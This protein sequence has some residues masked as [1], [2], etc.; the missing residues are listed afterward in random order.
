M[1]ILILGIGNVL[2]AD[3]GAGVHFVRAFEKAYKMHSSAHSV[4]FID[5]G[6]LANH[7]SPIIAEFDKA[8][9]VDCIESDDGALGDVYFFD[10]EAMPHFV[11]FSGSAH[12]VEMLQTL[13]MMDLLGDRPPT[14]ILAV[15]PQRIEPMSF[16]LSEALLQGAKVMEKTLVKYLCELDIKCEKIAEF[17]IQKVANEWENAQFNTLL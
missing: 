7:L 14:K 5:G 9:I 11:K 16:A 4:S 12:E 10:F 17:D 8:I 1:K 13:Q 15:V 6:T 2:F 3:E